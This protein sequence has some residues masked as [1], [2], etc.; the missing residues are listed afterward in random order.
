MPVVFVPEEAVVLIVLLRVKFAK[1]VSPVAVK[2][3]K[4]VSP[5]AVKF[6][7]TVSNEPSNVKLASP[8]NVSAVSLPVIIRL[9]A[10]L[11]KV[12]GLTNELPDVIWISSPASFVKYNSLSSAVLP[13]SVK[14]AIW[15]G[16]PAFSAT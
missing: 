6:P 12:N 10:L 3:A 9:S 2:F 11:F 16:A 7:V 8:F 4:V 5:V 1:V 13:K 14:S 15:S